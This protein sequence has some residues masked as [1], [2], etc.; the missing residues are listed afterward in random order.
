[1]SDAQI[2]LPEVQSST[3]EGRLK[4]TKGS[5]MIP[6]SDTFPTNVINFENKK[7][8]I[9]SYQAESTKGKN[10]VIDDNAVPRMIKPKYP[11]VGAQKVDERKIKTASRPKPTVKQLLDKYTSRKANNVFRRLGCNKHISSPSRH[12]GHHQRWLGITYDQ[13]HYFPSAP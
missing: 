2:S 11:E 4:F 8:L 5:K 10:V 6:H 13:L 1:M 7:I 12:R 9:R 3:D